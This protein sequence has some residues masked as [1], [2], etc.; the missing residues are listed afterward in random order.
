MVPFVVLGKLDPLYL[1]LFD[2]PVPDGIYV[3]FIATLPSDTQC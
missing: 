1:S 3:L 2:N